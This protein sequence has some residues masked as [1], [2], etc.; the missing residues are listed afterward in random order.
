[1]Q[2]MR[3]DF[4]GTIQEDFVL[5][6]QLWRAQRIGWV[7]LIVLLLCALTGFSGAGPA[8]QVGSVVSS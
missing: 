5:Q 6:Q 2:Q 8:Y 7:I 3:G 1:M 4:Q